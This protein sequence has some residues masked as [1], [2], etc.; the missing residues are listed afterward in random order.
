MRRPPGTAVLLALPILLGCSG[1]ARTG[2]AGAEGKG[3]V[4]LFC[5][6]DPIFSEPIK[7]AFERETGIRVR[8]QT[9]TEAVKTVGLVNRLIARKDHPEADV[10]WN[11]EIGMTLVLQEKGVLEAYKPAAAAE[12]PERFK[13]PDGWW[14]GFASRARVIL[15][16]TDLVKP[17][18]APKTLADLAAPRFKDRA[19]ISKPLFGTGFTHAAALFETLGPD[20]AKDW[21]RA[22]KA[23]GVKVAAGNAMARNMV[24]DGEVAVCVTDTD[25][26]NGAFLKNRPVRM[27]Y[28]D[29][30]GAG[31]LVLPNS[32]ALIK[33]GPNPENAKKLIEFLVS[34]QVE[35]LLAKSESAQL[36]VR[37]GVEPHGERFDPAAFKAVEV[38]WTRL[39]ARFDEVKTFV[40]EELNW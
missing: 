5:S 1:G 31:A 37:P 25:D 7:E 40:Q 38:D 35:A 23:N 8:F 4:V 22:L 34:R 26:A 6:L 21:Y 39:A 17:E 27:I 11:N 30:D 16:N 13:D 28:P 33:G 18:D 10:F 32:V 36:P 19:A 2:D 12:I 15:Y 20:K 3:E 9:D 24:A 14:T 29:Q